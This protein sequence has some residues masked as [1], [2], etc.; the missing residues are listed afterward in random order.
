MTAEAGGGHRRGRRAVVAVVAVMAA[1]V[2][3]AGIAGVF[4]GSGPSAG[5]AAGGGYKTSTAV[6][7]R[8]S[9]TS[10]TQVA[11]TLGDAGSYTVVNQA[12]GTITGLPAVGKVIHQGKVLYR[13]SDSPVVLLYGKVPAYRPL[14]EGMTGRDVAELNRDLVRLGYATSGD[15][16]AVGWDYF[17]WD[18][19]YALELLQEHLGITNRTGSLG[20][21]DAVFL[22]TAAKVTAWG[23]GVVEGGA[24]TPGS[25]ILTATSTT[26]EVTIDLDA[27][28]QTEVKAGDK[29]AIALPDGTTTP[30]VITSVGPVASTDSSGTA[31]ITVQVALTHPKAAGRLNQ[32]PVT[33]SITTGSVTSALVVPVDALLAQPGGGYA[34][35]VTGPGGTHHLVKVSAGLFDDAAG[36]VQVSGAGL[37]AGQHVVVP[38]L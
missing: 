9:L 16:A 1:G 4:S 38:A 18:T 25:A 37:A 6:V 7:E 17:G 35:E 2:A 34:V 23:S 36:L 8:R 26:P 3:G 32:A 20:L 19:K 10:Q 28:Q 30:G 31:T 13:V 12:S 22:P 33:V 15:V 5:R 24:A 29:V 14:S 27:S 21:G 11:A